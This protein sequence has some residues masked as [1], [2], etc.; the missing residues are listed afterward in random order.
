MVGG[1]LSAKRACSVSKE[2]R[3]GQGVSQQQQPT[4]PQRTRS[5]NRIGEEGPSSTPSLF[6]LSEV[7]KQEQQKIAKSELDDKPETAVVPVMKPPTPG[8]PLSWKKH[9]LQRY[10][11][12]S[13]LLSCSQP[14]I[15]PKGPQLI[16]PEPLT[17]MKPLAIAAHTFRSPHSIPENQQTPLFSQQDQVPFSLSSSRPYQSTP[18]S[19]LSMPV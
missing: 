13:A 18:L 11:S 3:A 10:Y 5:E 7:C 17:V 1:S 8:R 9:L 4:K 12:D 15:S 14:R 19:P 2:R 6:D 16:R